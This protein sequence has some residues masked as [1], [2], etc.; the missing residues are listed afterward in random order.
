[1]ETAEDP[2]VERESL[3]G[4]PGSEA[5][6]AV[7]SSGAAATCPSRPPPLPTMPSADMPGPAGCSRVSSAVEWRRPRSCCSAPTRTCG[8]TAASGGEPAHRDA[9]LCGRQG[10]HKA[11]VRHRRAR[12][13]PECLGGILEHA[14]ERLA[15]SSRQCWARATSSTLPVPHAWDDARPARPRCTAQGEPADYPS[16]P[17]RRCQPAWARLHD[18]DHH[19]ADR[20]P[21]Q[22]AGVGLARV[23]AYVVCATGARLEASGPAAIDWVGRRS[24]RRPNAHGR[25]GRGPAGEA[26]RFDEGGCDDGRARRHPRLCVSNSFAQAQAGP[27]D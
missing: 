21:R 17:T 5:A 2:L 8:S 6:Q 14:D 27:R 13:R 20:L 11:A 15:P 7:A 25:G 24:R 1:M 22:A 4:R 3:V 19:H 10:Q 23:C 9:E 16:R 18:P 12:G 26:A